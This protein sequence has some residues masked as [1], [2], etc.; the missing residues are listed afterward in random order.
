MVDAFWLSRFSESCWIV[1][2]MFCHS[3]IELIEWMM[4]TRY[5][6]QHNRQVW[7]DLEHLIPLLPYEYNFLEY[8]LYD[9]S[10]YQIDDKERRTKV[11]DLFNSLSVNKE[12][13]QIDIHSC[14]WLILLSTEFMG[15]LF[16]FKRCA[17]DSSTRQLV[18]FP[19]YLSLSTRRIHTEVRHYYILSFSCAIIWRISA[20][21]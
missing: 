16:L 7:L 21:N 2:G 3:S 8:P 11:A 15:F 13:N 18:N 4:G 20:Q 10:T 17:F 12:L 5:H 19:L 14:W 9:L 6:C 1:G